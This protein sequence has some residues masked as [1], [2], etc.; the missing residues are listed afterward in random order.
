MDIWA[1]ELSDDDNFAEDQ[2]SD[3][4]EGD[5]DDD[6]EGAPKKQEKVDLSRQGD[7]YEKDGVFI[8][9][10]QVGKYGEKDS[11]VEYQPGGSLVVQIQV[12]FVY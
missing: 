4:E 12:R 8:N 2:D 3:G 9:V 7:I 1:G 10:L 5:D 6:D 11:A